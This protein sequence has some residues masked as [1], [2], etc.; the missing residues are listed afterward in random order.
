MNPLDP[1]KTIRVVTHDGKE[2]GRIPASAPN[3]EAYIT[4]LIHH[5]SRCKINYEPDTSGGLWAMM[6]Q[7]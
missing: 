3:A 5:Y 1:C 4:E 6:L 7:K 2:V